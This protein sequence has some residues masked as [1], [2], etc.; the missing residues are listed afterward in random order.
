MTKKI[1]GWVLLVIGVLAIVA[2]VWQSYQI[3]TNKTAAPEIFKLE[4]KQE[5]S[6]PKTSAKTQEEMINQQMEQLLQEQLG[7]LIPAD[8]VTKIL[9]LTVWS[10][11]MGILVLAAGKIATIGA[12]LLKF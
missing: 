10:I 5:T 4:K 12:S 2:G 3:F 11:F 8:T 1:I 6:L 9:N 7:K